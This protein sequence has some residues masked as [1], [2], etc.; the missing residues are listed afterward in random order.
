MGEEGLRVISSMQQIDQRIGSL[1][2]AQCENQNK[3]LEAIQTAQDRSRPVSIDSSGRICSD[4]AGGHSRSLE[5]HGRRFK[6]T[7]E[8]SENSVTMQCH[9]SATPAS[10]AQGK[11]AGLDAAGMNVG[12]VSPMVC[13]SVPM[14]PG[15][16]SKAADVDDARQPETTRSIAAQARVLPPACG[17]FGTDDSL[18]CLHN[19]EEWSGRGVVS[20]RQRH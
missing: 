12:A 9:M 10:G 11:D 3:L 15:D 13:E 19:L 14:R 8:N 17:G 18:D 5:A 16:V 4:V 20:Y 6:M 7:F 2:Q 1:E